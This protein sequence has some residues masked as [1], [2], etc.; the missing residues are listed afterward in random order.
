M[1]SWNGMHVS[2]DV[3][4]Y[5]HE[6]CACFTGSTR[7]V[8]THSCRDTHSRTHIL[9][10]LAEKDT[11]RPK[12]RGLRSKNGAALQSGLGGWDGLAQRACGSVG[13]GQ[14]SVTSSGSTGVG[15]VHGKQGAWGTTGSGPNPRGSRV[16]RRVPCS[17]PATQEA[18]CIHVYSGSRTF[19]SPKCLRNPVD[20]LFHSEP[21]GQHFVRPDMGH[22]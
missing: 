6:H 10:W 16:P 15:V 7:C 17:P 21:R 2:V 14:R 11:N 4:I 8:C 20:A 18:S 9:N 19:W 13:N 5:V 22:E 3:D 12:S 1:G